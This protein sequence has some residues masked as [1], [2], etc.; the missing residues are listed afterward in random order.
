MYKYIKNICPLPI[1]NKELGIII[2][3]IILGFSG[4]ET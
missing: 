3:I 2:I 4:T 1:H